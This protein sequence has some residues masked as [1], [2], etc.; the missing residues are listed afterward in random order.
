MAKEDLD[1]LKR[2]LLISARQ[3]AGEGARIVFKDETDAFA[4]RT[5]ANQLRQAAKDL[6]TLD[7]VYQAIYYQE[8]K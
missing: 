7:G 8:L 4:L 1:A 3:S 6:D 2:R 5:A